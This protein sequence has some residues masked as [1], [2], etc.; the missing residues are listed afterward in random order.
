MCLSSQESF[1]PTPSRNSLLL[2]FHVN[3]MKH[4]KYISCVSW[5]LL[6]KQ[7][8]IKTKSCLKKSNK[9]LQLLKSHIL[10]VQLLLECNKWL[11]IGEFYDNHLLIDIWPFGG[12]LYITWPPQTQGCEFETTF[13]N[14]SLCTNQNCPILILIYL[15]ALNVET[16]KL[17]ETE[18]TW[19]LKEHM[20]E[21]WTHTFWGQ[22]FGAGILAV[23][24]FYQTDFSVP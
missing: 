9:N 12:V 5:E 8:K 14:S 13:S 19:R 6:G 17:K 23:P 7:W 21:R 22:S 16:K 11:L 24:H 1:S 2:P 10:H 15:W 4:K 18:W 20:M 3:F